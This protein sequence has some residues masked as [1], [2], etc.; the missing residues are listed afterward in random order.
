MG[1]DTLDEMRMRPWAFVRDADDDSS[2][3]DLDARMVLAAAGRQQPQAALPVERVR[4]ALPV[5]RVRAALPVE[6]VCAALP[7]E[8]VCAALY[9]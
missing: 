4:A 1:L 6:C 5:E 2:G 9:L 3:T 8:C 7:V